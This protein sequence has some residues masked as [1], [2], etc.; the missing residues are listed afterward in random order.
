M[1]DGDGPELV[2][3]LPGAVP[4]RR[5]PGI[6]ISFRK[7]ATGPRDGKRPP[8]GAIW[9]DSVYAHVYPHHGTVEGEQ[10]WRQRWLATDERVQ[11]HGP[12]AVTL[13]VFVRRPSSHLRADG[14]LSPLGLRTPFPDVR[15]D[16]DNYTKVA[17]DALKTL[18]LEDD[19]KVVDLYVTKRY[20]HPE[21]VGA[22]LRIQAM[23]VPSELTIPLL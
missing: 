3:W 17:L 13:S 1:G 16:V 20:A 21:H 5:Q 15:P 4:V 12:V 18:A 9:R 7:G 8:P 2:L 22:E 23:P 19:G 6:E 11:I 14:T 10:R